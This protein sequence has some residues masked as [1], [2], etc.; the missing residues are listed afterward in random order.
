MNISEITSVTI[1]REQR[2]PLDVNDIFKHI[3]NPS[4]KDIVK[5]QKDRQRFYLFT[6][7]GNIY[8]LQDFSKI[9]SYNCTTYFLNKGKKNVKL[10]EVFVE[11]FKS[12]L[13]KEKHHGFK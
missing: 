9:V 11:H 1:L 3:H 10:I 5:A 13:I 8:G 2:K 12:N 7:N 6:L 4:W